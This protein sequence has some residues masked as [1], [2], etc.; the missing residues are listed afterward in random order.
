[1]VCVIL[2]VV[3]IG[4]GSDMYPIGSYEAGRTQKGQRQCSW[5]VRWGR[6]KPTGEESRLR[7]HQEEGSRGIGSH[8]HQQD[9]E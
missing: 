5:D 1:M 9:L 4:T 3:Q 7:E 8:A 6:G 2:P